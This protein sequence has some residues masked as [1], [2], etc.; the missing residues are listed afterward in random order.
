MLTTSNNQLTANPNSIKSLVRWSSLN[1][2][3]GSLSG[4][5]MS[6]IDVEELAMPGNT[7]TQTSKFMNGPAAAVKICENVSRPGWTVAKPPSG[8]R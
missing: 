6:P 3:R 1:W 8:E 7:A 4:F 5:K 2:A